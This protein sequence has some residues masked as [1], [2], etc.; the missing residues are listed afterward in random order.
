MSPRKGNRGSRPPGGPPVPNSRG[1]RLRS[2]LVLGVGALIGAVI[3]LWENAAESHSVP[4]NGSSGARTEIVP[5]KLSTTYIRQLVSEVNVDRLWT[6]FLKPMLIERQPGSAGNKQ[7]REFIVSHLQSL[8]SGWT[9]DLDLFDALTPRGSMSFGSVMATLDPSARQRIVLACHL[10]SKVFPHDRRGRPFVG[11]TDSAVP[12]SL[13][14]EAVTLLDTRLKQLKNKGSSL[15]LQLFFLDG[16]EAIVD[17]TVRDSLYGARH[18]AQHLKKAEIPGG[19]GS[20]LSAINLFILLDL[21]GAPDPVFTSHYS[22]TN[23]HFLRLRALEKRLHGLG[24]LKSHP[25]ENAYFR[26][27]IYYGPVEDDHIPFVK[28]GVPALHVISTPFP[29]VWHTHDDTEENLHRPTVIN[30][31]RIFVAFLSETLSL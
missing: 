11:A 6:T 25:F 4:D 1:F 16:E 27:D 2:V 13:I 3:L 14:L 26:N 28:Q 9:V 19:G 7:V 31:C 23:G 24:L 30:L 5:K 18:L 15:T 8:S 22:E 20:Q 10:D 17:W 12:C 21:L 29:A